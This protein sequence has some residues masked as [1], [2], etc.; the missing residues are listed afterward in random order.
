MYCMYSD[1]GRILGLCKP[2]FTSSDSWRKCLYIWDVEHGVF[3]SVLEPQ[4]LSEVDCGMSFLLN[5]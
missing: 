2:M 4:K 1:G 3:L 5:E